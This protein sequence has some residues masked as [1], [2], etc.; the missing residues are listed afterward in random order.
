MALLFIYFETSWESVFF[1][2]MLRSCSYF[3]FFCYTWTGMVKILVFLLYLNIYLYISF[4]CICWEIIMFL[5]ICY[6]W[7]G[8]VKIL[9]FL[10]YLNIYLYVHFYCICWEVIVFL[11]FCCTWTSTRKFLVSLLYLNFFFYCI[12]ILW[13]L[14]LL[15]LMLQVIFCYIWTFIVFLFLVFELT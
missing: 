5:F 13:L 4:D 11:F 6:T 12:C 9:V 14:F 10:L 8:S 1:M 7:T 3:L 2:R 15:C